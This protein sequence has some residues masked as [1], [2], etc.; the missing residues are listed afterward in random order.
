[1][2]KYPWPGNVRELQNAVE[3][4]IMLSNSGVLGEEFMFPR[5]ATLTR[6]S[7][8]SGENLQSMREMEESL[9]RRALKE[10][11]GNQAKAADLL[12]IHRN[13]IRN[14]IQEYGIDPLEP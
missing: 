12:K 11:G 9:I 7:D 8:G 14:K 2:E 10:S 1:M 3:R 4:A 13:T 5:G 6:Q